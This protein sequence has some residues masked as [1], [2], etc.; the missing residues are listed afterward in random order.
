MAQAAAFL[1]VVEK[2]YASALDDRMWASAL[3]GMADLLD[4]V[5]VSFEI[6]DKKSGRPMMIELGKRLEMV[7]SAEYL[8]YYG[9]ISPRVI[10]L[11]QMP[12]GRVSYDHLI[13]S[14]DEIDRDEFYNDC[15]APQGLR[16]FVAGHVLNTSGYAGVIAAQ[17]SPAQDHVGKAE[18]E[19]VR[20]L[21]PHVSQAL[22]MKFRLHDADLQNDSLLGGLEGLGEAAVV[23]D[24]TG[25]VLRVNSAAAEVFSVG[26]GVTVVDR[27][28]CFS[29]RHAAARF[30]AALA[31]LSTGMGEADDIGRR[32]FAAHRPSKRRPYLVALRPLPA[33][34][35]TVLTTQA[36]AIVFIRDPSTF[37]RLDADLLRESYDLTAA[38]MDIACAIDIGLSVSELAKQ[39]GV[40]V[41]TVRTQLYALMAKLDVNRQTDLIRLLQQYRR[42]F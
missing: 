1:D 25:A 27:R 14:D 34:S 23:I 17:R 32:N 15:L 37:V 24:R 22:D 9:E 6:I 16:Y 10:R 8:N 2:I 30:E 28:I 7:N 31:G 21:L 3:D 38:E 13:I 40:A 26:D 33:P 29:D 19:I 36:A 42:P 41:S 11:G 20:R 12:A 39:R 4:A 18:V 5:G 35:A